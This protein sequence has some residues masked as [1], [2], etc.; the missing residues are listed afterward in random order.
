[1]TTATCPIDSMTIKLLCTMASVAI[2]NSP[3]KET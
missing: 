1:M 2:S 3:I